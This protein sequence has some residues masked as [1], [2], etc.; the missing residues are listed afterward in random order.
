MNIPLLLKGVGELHEMF[1]SGILHVDFQGHIETTKPKQSKDVNPNIE[2][3]TDAFLIF[4]SIYS[5]R[6]PEK[7]QEL[8]KYMSVIRYAAS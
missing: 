3:W 2:G 7:V 1:S 8:F 5:V 6:Y 4:Y